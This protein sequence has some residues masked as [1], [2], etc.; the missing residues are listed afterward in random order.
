ML[1]RQGISRYT[2]PHCNY[3]PTCST[4]ALEAIGRFGPVRGTVLAAWRL[5]R[6]NPWSRGGYDPV[7]EH[8]TLHREYKVYALPPHRFPFGTRKK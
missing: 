6:C 5:L 8:F 1:Y 7:P 4:Y 2:Q 3:V